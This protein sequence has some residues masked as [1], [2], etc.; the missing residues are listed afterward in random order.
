MTSIPVADMV[1]EVSAL[2]R[3]KLSIRGRSLAA[4]AGKARRI[5]PKSVR[6][7]AVYLSKTV[8]IAENPKLLRMI[9]QTRVEAAYRNC[10]RSLTA[11]DPKIRRKEMWLS[12]M[13]R[14]ALVIV[15]VFALVVTTLVW[16]GY[17]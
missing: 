6:A 13:N 9:D 8:L 4:Q 7:D 17:L 12:I 2:M 5:L 1:D 10:V 14:L 15:A 11:I 3:E 16:R